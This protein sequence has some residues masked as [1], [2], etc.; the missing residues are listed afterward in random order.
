MY[1]KSIIEY[2]QARSIAGAW[3][4][5]LIFLPVALAL[6]VA[7][8][9]FTLK[10]QYAGYLQPYA[11]QVPSTTPL[12]E[13]QSVEAAENP[14][15]GL[16]HAS[17]VTGPKR[18][19]LPLDAQQRAIAGYIKRKYGVSTEVVQELVRTAFAAGRRYG[20]DPLLVVA[21][22]AVESGYNPIA[23]SFAGA[24][25][26]MQIIPKYHLEKFVEY[27]GE[28]AV[29]DPR[30]NI[31]VGARIVRE[32]L[33]M[34]SGDLLTALQ[35]YAGAMADRE[36]IYTQRV[37]N[38]KDQL[39]ALAGFPK[40]QRNNR[41][42]MHL[43]PERS[44]AITVPTPRINLMIEPQTTA[45]GVPPQPSQQTS[46]AEEAAHTPPSQPQPAALPA[47]NLTQLTP[48]AVRF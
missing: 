12:T 23:E 20:V 47:V 26:L 48:N 33:L 42:V 25:G 43:E 5:H 30:V 29:F 31:L 46:P 13:P 3:S 34:H 18:T 38:E 15:I 1:A 32:Y 41:I 4:Q 17:V 37:L 19:A 36:A 2:V 40:T 11:H 9:P 6:G 7:V 22:M 24:K 39:D 35:T 21:M 45:P 10:T 14:F 44:G 8:L 27:G 28:H 16:V